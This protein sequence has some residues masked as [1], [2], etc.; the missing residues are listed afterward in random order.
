MVISK[1]HFECPRC[2]YETLIK[3]LIQ[4]HMNRKHI[5]PATVTDIEL[6]D[7]IKRHILVNHKYRVTPS[8]I[9]VQIPVQ[10]TNFNI[11][12][13]YLPIELQIGQY[14][15]VTKDLM[16]E[17]LDDMIIRSLKA[18][19]W[20]DNIGKNNSPS[21]NITI[22]DYYSWFDKM[23]KL[24]DNLHDNAIPDNI[25]PPL[26]AKHGE[27][28]TLFDIPKDEQLT[29]NDDK[30]KAYSS[31]HNEDELIKMIL[32]KAMDLYFNAY[33][34]CLWEHA[35]N[36][37]RENPNVIKAEHNLIHYYQMLQTFGIDSDQT[38]RTCWTRADS[39]FNNEYKQKLHERFVSVVRENSKLN[40]ETIMARFRNTC[41]L[42]A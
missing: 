11:A 34:I 3:Q 35:N 17:N 18:A 25:I 29:L 19:R 20:F 23:T 33:E 12:F 30:L 13:N 40:S 38:Y 31:K 32:R 22:S 39:M 37:H 28:I 27:K 14:A 26:Y 1:S 5:C 2:G 6:T 7:K 8:Q 10:V 42:P 24:E 9:N 16:I 4:K 36:S 21:P 41:C 15:S